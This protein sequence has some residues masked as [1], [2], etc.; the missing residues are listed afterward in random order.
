MI[1]TDS[2]SLQSLK[3]EKIGGTSGWGQSL[4]TVSNECPQLFLV[5][6]GRL[7]QDISHGLPEVCAG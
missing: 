3:A 2:D 1:V 7:T 6:F 4:D 5:F